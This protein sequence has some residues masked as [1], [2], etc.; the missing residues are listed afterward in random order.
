[1]LVR[2][3]SRAVARKQA[4]MATDHQTSQPPPTTTQNQTKPII[5]SLLASPRFKAFTSESDQIISPTSIIDSVKPFSA[6]RSP[7]QQQPSPKFLPETKHQWEKLVEYYSKG[8]GVALIA[9]SE[10]EKKPKPISGLK[11]RVQIPPPLLPDSSSPPKSPAEFG[12]RT[13]ISNPQL[14]DSS[15]ESPRVVT[16]CLSATEMELSEDYTCVISRG[17]NPKTTHI[18]DNCVVENY[19]GVSEDSGSAVPDNKNF[20]S[21]C[22]TCKKSLEQKG[23]IFIYRGEKAFCSG[24]CRYQEMVLDGGLEG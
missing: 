2:H 22:Y 3:R 16:E 4:S 9:D 13:R 11:L 21:I 24:E 10:S 14:P 1:M 18:F 20:L 7:F 23:D 15:K 19:F 12:I 6:L 5:Q 17:A 8:I